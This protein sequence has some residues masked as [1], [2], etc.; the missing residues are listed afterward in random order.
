MLSIIKYF[1]PYLDFRSTVNGKIVDSLSG[2]EVVED[3]ASQ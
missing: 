2:R 3:E 1:F